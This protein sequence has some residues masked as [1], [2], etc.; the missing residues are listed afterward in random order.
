VLFTIDMNCTQL[1]RTKTE[2]KVEVSFYFFYQ[3]YRAI[4]KA[5]LGT[6]L[7]NECEIYSS[8]QSQQ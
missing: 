2:L 3:L 5:A 6:L 1:Q 8:M 7:S 4:T